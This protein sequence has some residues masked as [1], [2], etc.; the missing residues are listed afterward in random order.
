MKLF[1]SLLLLLILAL[2]TAALA[3]DPGS[4]QQA[5]RSEIEG[6]LTQVSP[7]PVAE[8]NPYPDCYYTCKVNINQILSGRSIP[9]KVI[10][11][12]PGFFA[13]R[14]APEAKF[15]PGDKI[16]ATVVSFAS[17]PESVRQTQ[18]A[19]EIDDVNLEILFP[20]QI[21]TI[22]EFQN[23]SS[24]IPFAGGVAKPVPVAPTFEA[25]DLGAKA[26]RKEQM[27][28]DLAEI[29]R[30]LAKHGGNWDAWFDSLKD[31]RAQ[32]S[33]A[34]A[35]K[36]QKWVG[37]SFFSAG[38]L[39]DSK[40]Y[41]PEFIKSA[42]AFKNYLSARNVD[43][44][45]VRVPMKG[46]LVDDLFA[47]GAPDGIFN[48][49]LLRLYKELLEADVEIITDVIAAAKKQRLKYPL[50]YWYQDF[51]EPHPA[52]GIAWVVADAFAKRA[53]RYER[54]RA[55]Q[56]NPVV[57]GK[58]DSDYTW[59]PGN[60]KFST[61][62]RIPFASVTYNGPLAL[63]Q[64]SDSP[65]LFLGSSF[66]TAPSLEKG[67]SIPQYFAYLTGIVPDI[68]QR[69]QGD[70][71]T[72]RNV[73]REPDDFIRKRSVCLF[74]ITPW[75][76]Y[77]RF[78]PLP[79]FDP[80]RSEKTMLASYSGRNLHSG[81]EFFPGTP[82]DSFAYASNGLL[83][84]WP[85]NKNRDVPVNFKIS[86]PDSLAGYPYFVV[87]IGFGETDRTQVTVQYSGQ[88][89]TVKRSE[90]QK[91]NEEVFAFASNSDK[92]L[93]VNLTANEYYLFPAEIKYLKVFGVTQPKY[94]QGQN[95][96]KQSSDFPKP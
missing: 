47:P 90:M 82:K 12:L 36:A 69:N 52:E 29:N 76:P 40:M 84:I 20:E 70:V 92:Y 41:G 16:R 7:L 31:Y 9:A 10:L 96:G 33:K 6:T 94:Y 88:S 50:M 65:V 67:G 86:L 17:Q 46:E 25:V 58:A 19:D 48:P 83:R 81:I 62:G 38:D 5:E 18:Q 23:V 35:S 26:A 91:N 14:Y 61:A 24:T 89:D 56:R 78:V 27:R 11:V 45:L 28:Q 15:K 72:P 63:R 95:S 73:L 39:G 79:V 4:A 64:G 8:G 87:S 77:T 85:A 57:L 44:I 21:S 13:R 30:L 59:P 51:P 71:M 49:Y 60:D 66:L 75:L 1:L 43:L 34:F 37:D 22:K 68:F 55:A 93:S 32:Y 2:P 42:V 3:Q 80:D 74:P 53:A 54:V